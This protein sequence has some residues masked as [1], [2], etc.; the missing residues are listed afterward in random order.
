MKNQKKN[1]NENQAIIKVPSQEVTAQQQV[2]SPPSIIIQEKIK[3]LEEAMQAEI[4]KL[5][6]Q[7][8]TLQLTEEQKKILYAPINEEDIEVR[9]DGLI[10]LPWMEYERRLREAFGLEWCLLPGGNPKKE[11]NL[12]LWGFWLIIKGKPYGFAYG[13]Q[14]YFETN[15]QMT[16]GDACEGAKSNAL[17]RLCKGL[18]IG[19]ELWKP[20][21]IKQWKEKYAEQYWE[22]DEKK[23]KKVLKW[24]KKE[25]KTKE[26]KPKEKKQPVKTVKKIEDKT[27][28]QKQKERKKELV[29]YFKKQL[30]IR[31]I[32]Y[33]EFKEWLF[34]IQEKKRKKYVGRKFGKLSLYEGELKD[35]ELLLKYWG[36]VC[37]KF[38]QFK[39]ELQEKE[40]FGVKKEQQKLF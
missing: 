23:K 11:G 13:Q 9:P 26:E 28:I 36:Q 39:K 32:N 17:M 29:E 5:I 38:V 25:I 18:G 19:T 12:I 8:G 14:E 6:P 40:E 20:S 15:P 10:Y 1:N 37:E 4:V 16:W 30:E 7:A 31:G 33:Q 2:V 3:T 35:L 27:I 21:F 22:Y 34:G 24:R